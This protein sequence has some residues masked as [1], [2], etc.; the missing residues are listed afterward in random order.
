MPVE[1][2]PLSAAG[3]SREVGGRERPPLH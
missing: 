1:R 2:R 3:F